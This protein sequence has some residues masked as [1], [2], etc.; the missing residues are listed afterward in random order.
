MKVL[1]VRFSSIGDIVLT[2]PV[3]RCLKLQYDQAEIHYLTKQSYRDLLVSNPYIDKLWLYDHNFDALLP[4]LKA[5][6]FSFI[7]DLH[8]NWRSRYIRL[9][10]G[11]SGASFPK[12]NFKKWLLVRFH[13]D[14]MPDIHIVDRYFRAVS[15]LGV[16]NDMNGLDFVTP[17]ADEVWPGDLP[18]A[19]RKGFI[20]VVIGGKHNTKIY[21]A[22]KVIEVCRLLSQPVVLIGGPEDRERGAY[23]AERTGQEVL[24]CCGIYNFN[25]SASLIRQA[26][27]VLTN[28]TGMMHIAAALGKPIVSVWGNTVPAFGMYPF[29][30]KGS[31]TPS[32]MA[33]VSDL[34]CRPCSKLGYKRCPRKHFRCMND[35]YPGQIAAYLNSM[36]IETRDGIG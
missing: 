13:I 15:A 16:V 27:A 26:S 25:Q 36:T 30:K 2:T 31:E 4:R 34:R 23:I 22:D 33:G 8:K 24:N 12:L 7:V 28:D 6:Q 11:V 10:L 1:I 3:V 18:P 14:L 9:R 35:I 21:P 29:L 5:Q 17:A 32:V 20:A 19:H